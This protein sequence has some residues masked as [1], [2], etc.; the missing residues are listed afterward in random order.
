MLDLG[1]RGAA[2]GK[3]GDK[4]GSEVGK[5]E[6]AALRGLASGGGDAVGL[7][8]SM[9]GEDGGMSGTG[10]LIRELRGLVSA[11]EGESGRLGTEGRALS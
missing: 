4:P 5:P 10:K 3:V 9:V 8:N 11:A 6:E 1:L 7:G 2:G